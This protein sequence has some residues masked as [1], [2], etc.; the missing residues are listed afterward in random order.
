MTDE[1]KRQLSAHVAEVRGECYH[2]WE[3]GEWLPAA[4]CT[5]ATCKH[6]GLELRADCLPEQNWADNPVQSRELLEEWIAKGYRVNTAHILHWSVWIDS[7]SGGSVC[8]R[9][10]RES[11]DV[12][13]C[14]AYCQGMG[15]PFNGE[16]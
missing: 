6:C 5:V 12:A 2:Y 7:P 16:E 1:Q 13:I 8:G 14:L 11:L 9:G 3:F 15:K 4:R 10:D